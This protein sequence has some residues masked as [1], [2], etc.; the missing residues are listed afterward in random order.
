[1]SV[2]NG[3]IKFC[4]GLNGTENVSKFLLQKIKP[5]WKQ[6]KRLK[7]R[8]YLIYLLN[9]IIPFDLIFDIFSQFQLKRYERYFL[10]GNFLLHTSY[11]FLNLMIRKIQQ[12]WLAR[13]AWNAIKKVTFEALKLRWQYVDVS[14]ATIHRIGWILDILAS[15]ELCRE[16]F[17]NK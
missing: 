12:I 13:R 5:I 2:C 8:A 17:L 15:D 11:F 7:D 14:S 9:G 1:M 10:L 16:Q 4:L 3:V 6:V